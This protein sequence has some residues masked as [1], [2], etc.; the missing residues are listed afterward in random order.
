MEAANAV[1][2][3]QREAGALPQAPHVLQEPHAVRA[4]A[5]G[6]IDDALVRSAGIVPERSANCQWAGI[7]SHAK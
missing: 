6:V 1:R 7:H 2:G 3:C 5:D 4:M